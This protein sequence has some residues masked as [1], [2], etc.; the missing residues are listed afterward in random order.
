MSRYFCVYHVNLNPTILFSNTRETQGDSPP[1]L[2]LELLSITSKGKIY[3]VLLL[4]NINCD[5]ID[6][7]NEYGVNNA[8]K[9]KNKKRNWNLSC[10]VKGN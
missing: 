5:K 8:K 7:I 3:E 6:S 9:T 4:L 10:Y 2:N 1:V